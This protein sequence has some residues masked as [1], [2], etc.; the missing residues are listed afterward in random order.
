MIAVRR[1]LFIAAITG[2]GLVGGAVG[3]ATL[4]PASAATVGIGTALHAV[5]SPSPTSNES[6][7]HE[8]GETAAQE[9]AEANGHPGG[10]PGGPGHGP[11]NC[12]NETSAHETT[13]TAAQEA[14]ES[15]TAC[16]S[17]PAKTP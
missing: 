10:G 8:A 2:A 5:A 15:K 12:S 16:P 11:G 7:A 1:L 3:A 9:A 17:P 14:A 6:A 4:I 13:E